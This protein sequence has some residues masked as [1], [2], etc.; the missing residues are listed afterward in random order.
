MENFFV[1]S[2]TC[3]AKSYCDTLFFESLSNLTYEKKIIRII[4]NSQNLAYLSRLN[5]IKEYFANLKNNCQIQHI[6][7]QFE[8][9]NNLFNRAV[10]ESLKVLR[11]QFL[12]SD[13]SH[14]ITIESDV[15]APPNL[16]ELFC[17]V[18]NCGADVIG[19]LYYNYSQHTEDDYK[20]HDFVFSSGE[21]TGC[22]CFSRKVLEEI[23]F[24]QGEDIACFPDA[25][26]SQDAVQN[27][28][29][30]GRYRKIKCG[31]LDDGSGFRGHRDYL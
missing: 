19:G 29:K 13:C 11:E 5:A 31:H 8:P 9:K 10:S 21:L 23:E 1:C 7:I 27:G 20:N 25:Y 2:Y 14:F 30:L 12:Q 3:E 6:D 28:F 24:R 22:T 17:E 16:L 15:I 26:F 4:D 18:L